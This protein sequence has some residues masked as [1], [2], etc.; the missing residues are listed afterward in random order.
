LVIALNVKVRINLIEKYSMMSL[1]RWKKEHLVIDLYKQGRT[2][3]EIAKS[4]HMSFRDIGTII[5]EQEK[6]QEVKEVQAQQQYL[7]SQA[8]RLFSK[9]KT[10]VQVGI[11]LNLRQPD[12]TTLFAE[13]CKLTKLENLSRIYEE[14]KDDIEPFLELYRLT[15]A[16]GMSVQDVSRVLAV[17]NSYLPSVQNKYD[18]LKREIAVLE[19]DKR[20]STVVF[21]DL[22]NQILAMGTSKPHKLNNISSH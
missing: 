6:K 9:G 15:K 2:S 1:G 3:K 13:Y 4:V 8:Y 10:P 19:G 5:H 16:A 22:N 7:S 12:V 17:A 20:N 21:Q 11:E 14:L 18:D